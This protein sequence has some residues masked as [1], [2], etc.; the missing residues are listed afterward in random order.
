MVYF[1]T[2]KDAQEISKRYNQNNFWESRYKI[3]DYKLSTFNYFICGWNEFNNPLSEKPEVKAFDMRGTTFVFN[4]DGSLYKRFFMLPKFF[5]INQIEATQYYKIKDKEIDNISTKED[6][7]LVA[8]MNLPNKKLFS[9]TIGS[10]VSEQSQ[11]AYRLLYTNEEHVIWVKKVLDLGYTPLFE[12]VSWDNRIVILY[13][14][15]QLRLIGIRNNATGEYIPAFKEFPE[16][17]NDIPK[18]IETIKETKFSLDELLEKAKKEENVEGWV[19][20]FKDGTLIKVKTKWYFKIHGLRTE[21][22]FR[23]DYIIKNYIEEKIDDLLS[24]LD[25]NLDSDAFNFVDNVENAVNNW[26]K[27]IDSKTFQLK[28]SYKEK[29]KSNWDDFAT[30]NHKEAYFGLATTLIKDPKKYKDRKIELILKRTY[31]L[32]RAKEIVEKWKK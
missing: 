22:I 7:S 10:F 32:K 8:F 26:I 1:L 18:E 29:Y 6:G 19:V 28:T 27:D 25:P 15:E 9:K 16:E 21:N 2:Y 12:Y 23:E 4:K 17:I 31:K 11:K 30:N 13:N 14:K 24:Q 5:N 20:M 3:E